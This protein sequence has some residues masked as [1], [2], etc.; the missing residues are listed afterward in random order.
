MFERWSERKQNEGYFGDRRWEAEA[1]QH[2]GE[3]YAE[4]DRLEA[5]L[6]AVKRLAKA[7]VAP[8][9]FSK[10]VFAFA[11]Y[12]VAYAACLAVGIDPKEL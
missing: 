3:C 5:Q 12:D 7:K 1:S 2:I 10:D 11:K 4:L 6:E 8:S 9:A